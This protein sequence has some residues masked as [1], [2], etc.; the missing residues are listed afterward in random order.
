[1]RYECPGD[2]V[3]QHFYFKIDSTEEQIQQRLCSRC[4]ILTRNVR[5]YY[6]MC[7]CMQAYLQ[8]EDVHVHTCVLCN[9]HII[10]ITVSASPTAELGT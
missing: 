6:I 7:V 2:F 9:V 8:S 5:I 10:S 4:L 1:M 3:E